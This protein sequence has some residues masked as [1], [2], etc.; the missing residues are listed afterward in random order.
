MTMKLHAN[1]MYPFDSIK[2]EAQFTHLLKEFRCLVC[3]NQDLADSNASLA[4]DLRSKIYDMV[5]LGKNDAEINDYMRLRYG[6]FILFKPPVQGLTILLWFGPFLFL[7]LG[8]IIFWR[9]C[10]K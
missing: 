5:R 9:A 4:K 6:D 10:F 8:F 1:S 3:Q 7:I 2:K